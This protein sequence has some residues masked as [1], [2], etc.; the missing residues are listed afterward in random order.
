MKIFEITQFLEKIAPTSYQE[1]YD[2]AGLI[3][4]NPQTEVTSVLISLDCLE[5]T[6]EEALQTNCNLIIAHHP[7]VFKGLKR[8]NGNGYVER[9][10]LKAI[11]NDIA[12]YAIHTNLDNVKNGV[13]F[14]IAQKLG[15]KNIKILAPKNQILQKL[16]I[17]VPLTHTQPLLDAL[18]TAGAGQVGNYKNC[19]FRTQGIGTFMPNQQAKAFIGTPNQQE[20]VTENRV[21]VVFP[22]HLQARILTAMYANHPY[23]EVAYFLQNVENANQEVGSGAIGELETEMSEMDFLNFLKQTMKSDCV[24][25]TALLGK[26]IKKIALC[27]GTGSFLL[28]NAIRQKADIY[29][30][31]DFKYH[32]FFDA[33]NRIVIADIGHYE[34]EQFTSELLQGLLKNEFQSLKTYI[35]AQNTNP[36]NYL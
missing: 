11:K 33:D 21:E 26:N 35:T 8:L 16:T 23:E 1:S 22:T 28:N 17:F 2:N 19:S 32:E 36:V 34:S 15:L 6:I 4:G 29:I 9:T 10:I 25:Y 7:I 31:A 18:A 13:N 27:G 30:S 5:K 12:I 20:E 24:K 3:V 14:K